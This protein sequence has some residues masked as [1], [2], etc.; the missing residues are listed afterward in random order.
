MSDKAIP[1]RCVFVSTKE[2]SRAKKHLVYTASGDP[3]TDDYE[4][5]VV[6]NH[7]LDINYKGQNF[8]V[9]LWD[10]SGQEEYDKLRPM[11]YAKCDVAVM[12]YRPENKKS[13]TGLDLYVKEV[14]EYADNSTRV[15]VGV[16]LDKKED[17]EEDDGNKEP[18]TDADVEEWAKQ[19]GIYATTKQTVKDGEKYE[20]LIEFFVENYLATH[21]KEKDN[22]LIA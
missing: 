3:I 17:D 16:D 13:L 21:K 8:K 20:K 9:H 18:V 2:A 10:T 1:I 6:E 5:G 22:C 7:C 19:N 12:I 4:P 14:K 15:L 11:S